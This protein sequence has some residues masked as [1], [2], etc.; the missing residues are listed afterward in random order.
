MNKS[1][2]QKGFTLIELMV[3]ITILSS[4]MILQMRVMQTKTANL[5]VEQLVVDI[6]EVAAATNLYYLDNCAGPF[7]NQPSITA[8]NTGGYFTQTFELPPGTTE[9][10]IT[11]TNPN[12][13]R[14]RILIEVMFDDIHFANRA[15]KKI[16]SAKLAEIEENDDSAQVSFYY[17]IYTNSNPNA[18]TQHIENSIT[19][20]KS[21]Y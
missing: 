10:L 7:F 3:L 13:A 15:A 6:K 21:C 16:A 11:V 9:T 1:I 17:P 19:G 18:V 14:A 12:T 20:F 4:A 2:H 5:R 8:L